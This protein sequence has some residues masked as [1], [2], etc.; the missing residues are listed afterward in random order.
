ML[1]RFDPAATAPQRPSNDRVTCN[2]A[3]DETH[4]TSHVDAT[5]TCSALCG[6]VVLFA[7]PASIRFYTRSNDLLDI[8]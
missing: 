4:P 7:R 3:T 8:A 1:W 6:G 5:D 2:K